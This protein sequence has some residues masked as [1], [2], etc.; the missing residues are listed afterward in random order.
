[1]QRTPDDDL[2]TDD[3]FELL[4]PVEVDAVERDRV[5]VALAEPVQLHA[6][7]RGRSRQSM[8]MSCLVSSITG[9]WVSYSGA[10]DSGSRSRIIAEMR[11]ITSE[12]WNP[13]S[14]M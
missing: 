10:H 7:H 14:R 4:G 8:P 12:K 11:S 6:G 2:P 13:A 1:M 9:L 5:A 3:L